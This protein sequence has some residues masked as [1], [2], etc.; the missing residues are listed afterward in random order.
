M[1]HTEMEQVL[2]NSKTLEKQSLASLSSVGR[3][4][5]VSNSDN[6]FEASRKSPHSLVLMVL[7]ASLGGLLFGFNTGIIG[8]VIWSLRKTM[9]TDNEAS[10]IVSIFAAAAVFGSFFC[11][12]LCDR[13][14]RKTIIAL[15]SVLCLLGGIV[16]ASAPNFAL[17]VL[18]RL[19]CGLS[20]GIS[21]FVVPTYI[22]E[23]APK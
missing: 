1:P 8:S 15:S 16:F 17:L 23:I 22:A 18:G 11:G 13:Y 7:V 19:I 21:S 6:G 2:D 4:A 9:V 5:I 14:G 3:G 10:V 12:P 20:I